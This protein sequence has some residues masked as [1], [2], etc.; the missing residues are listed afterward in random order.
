MFTE[1]SFAMPGV[2]LAYSVLA[3]YFLASA[4]RTFGVVDVSGSPALLS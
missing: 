2:V 4:K 3:S 1:A